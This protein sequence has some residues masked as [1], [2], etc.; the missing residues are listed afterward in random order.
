M[1][2]YVTVL[3]I[4]HVPQLLSLNNVLLLISDKEN[5]LLHLFLFVKLLWV[6]MW[7]TVLGLVLQ[8]LGA[9]LGNATGEYC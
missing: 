6:L 5:I 4:N 8:L 7:S 1:N 3:L 9:R 2:M